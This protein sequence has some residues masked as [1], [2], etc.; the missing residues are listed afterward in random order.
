MQKG[1][2][3][4]EILLEKGFSDL[5]RRRPL[6]SHELL[7][8]HGARLSRVAARAFGRRKERDQEPRFRRLRQGSAGLRRLENRHRDDGSGV[9]NGV[10]AE[11]FQIKKLRGKIYEKE[12]F[13]FN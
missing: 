2:R 3:D 13:V 11:A 6:L 4:G 10:S 1:F 5:G 7:P 12:K 9:Q 8:V